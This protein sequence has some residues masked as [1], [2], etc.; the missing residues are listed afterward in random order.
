MHP[1]L[2]RP[3]P[4][5]QDEINNLHHCHATTSKVSHHVH[6]L[7][8]IFDIILLISNNCIF[9]SPPHNQPFLLL[10]PPII[11]IILGKVKF[12]GCNEIKFALD[13][14]LKAE[15]LKLLEVIYKDADSKRARE[16]EVF[17]MALGKEISFEDYLMKD[18]DFRKAME[19]KETK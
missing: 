7:Y 4:D 12:W 9:V 17:Q 15:K 2:D 19:G 13:K 1:P 6:Y 8:R 16:E 3:H 5:C 14:C 10:E 18:K 11:P